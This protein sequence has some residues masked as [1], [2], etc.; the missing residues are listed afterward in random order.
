MD[1]MAT[2]RETATVRVEDRVLVHS[3]RTLVYPQ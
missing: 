1:A 3:H 2:H